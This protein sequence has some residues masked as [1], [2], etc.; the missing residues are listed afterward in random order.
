LAGPPR[1]GLHGDTG[2]GGQD[3]PSPQSPP[4]S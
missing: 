2:S 1:R 4:P 3:V